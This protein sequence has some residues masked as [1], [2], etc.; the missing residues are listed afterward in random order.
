[1]HAS[2]NSDPHARGLLIVYVVNAKRRICF[3]K[4][5]SSPQ[6]EVTDLFLVKYYRLT[7]L[8]MLIQALSRCLQASLLVC[9]TKRHIAFCTS[10]SRVDA[11]HDLYDLEEQKGRGTRE[12]GRWN[13]NV[14][15]NTGPYGC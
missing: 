14:N 4:S 15:S 7:R 10:P 8:H 6:N 12:P 11:Y 5:T 1:M 3:T 9:V 13:F 2:A